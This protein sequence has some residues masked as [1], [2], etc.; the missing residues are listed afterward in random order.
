[1]AQSEG[2]RKVLLFGLR[3]SYLERADRDMRL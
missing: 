3:L 1:V 2:G